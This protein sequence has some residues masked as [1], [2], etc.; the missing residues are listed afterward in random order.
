MSRARKKGIRV[1]DAPVSGG[2]SGTQRYPFPSWS[3]ATRQTLPKR[4][5]CSSA[6]AKHHPHGSCRQRTAHQGCRQPDCRSRSNRRLHRGA[7]LAHRR[8]DWTR[9]RCSAIGAGAQAAGSDQH[10]SACAGRRFCTGFFHQALYQRI[11][12]CAGG[13]PQEAIVELEMLDTVLALYER[14]HS[15]DWKTTAPRH[16]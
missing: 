1:M 3:A 7:G 15:R 14:W 4:C 16:S 9:R 6:W 13:K 11:E 2:D 5:R 8:R 10:G 12:D